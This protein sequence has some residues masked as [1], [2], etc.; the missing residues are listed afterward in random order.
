MKAELRQV[1]DDLAL[2]DRERMA[3]IRLFPTLV[4]ETSRLS[5]PNTKPG[6]TG[7]P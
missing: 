7:S 2:S 4:Q 1:P 5:R 6:K 3:R